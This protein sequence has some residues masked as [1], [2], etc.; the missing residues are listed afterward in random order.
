MKLTT[1]FNPAADQWNAFVAKW[2]DFELMQSYE[3][4]TYKEASGWKVVRLAVEQNGQWVAGVQM[5]IKPL[6]LDLTSLIYVPRGP[7][8]PWDNEPVVKTLLSAMHATAQCHR[9]ISLKIEPPVHYSVAMQQRLEA[10]GFRR[11]SFTNQPQ[12]SMLIDLTLDPDAILASMHKTTRY[13]IGY[14]ARQGVVVREAAEAD[15]EAFYRLMKHTAQR[16]GFPA[17]SQ[18]YYRQE[19]D[20]FAPL[21]RLKLFMATY[22]GEILA[23]RMPAIMGNK[24]ATFHSASSTAHR[25]I[26]PNE[27]LMWESLQWAK[28]QGCTVYDVWG[29]PNEVGEHLFENKPLPEEQKGGLWGVYNFKRGF[30]GELVYYIGAY[31]Y[32]YIRPLHWLMDSAISRLGSLDKL[33]QLGD[34]LNPRFDQPVGI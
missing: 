1:I 29:I 2:P 21:G 3:W 19:W 15:F 31:D 17:R 23:V 14:S 8:M 5:L 11:S 18:S 24:A 4:G 26:K 9:A 33:A 13:N 6:P 30:G 25:N 20:T 32:I 28:S 10:Y 12:C 16:V 7:L 22:Q 27:L 34:R